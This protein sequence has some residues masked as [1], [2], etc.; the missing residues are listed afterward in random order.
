MANGLAQR[1]HPLSN[2]RARLN[3][4]GATPKVARSPCPPAQRPPATISPC[5]KGLNK[6]PQPL[7]VVTARD[8]SDAEADAAA[9]DLVGQ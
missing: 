2:G 1:S 9:A 8:V 6:A 5:R 3:A 4:A 7:V